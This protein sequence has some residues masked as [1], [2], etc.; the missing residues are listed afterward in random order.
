METIKKEKNIRKDI[1]V[2]VKKTT[3]SELETILENVAK[4]QRIFRTYNQK[5][6]DEIFRAAAFAAAGQRIHLAKMAVSETGM[7]VIEDKVI[8]TDSSFDL[9][10][11]KKVE[12][13]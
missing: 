1:K 7:G 8:K 6:V 10:L 9:K 11:D 13:F 3:V 2:D 4:A 12:D 5:K